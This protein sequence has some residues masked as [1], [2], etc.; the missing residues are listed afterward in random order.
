MISKICLPKIGV[1]PQST[2]KF[3]KSWII[4]LVKKNA[5]FQR[6]SLN[7][8]ITTLT[9]LSYFFSYSNFYSGRNVVSYPGVDVMITI[10]D[11]KI[12]V[13]LKNRCYDQFFATTSSRLSKNAN[14][15]AK[16]FGKNT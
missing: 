2:A 12:G 8:V 4:S 7:L 14:I 3:Y 15:F 1:L 11:E 9:P 5:I 10:F 13:F 16:F 6:K